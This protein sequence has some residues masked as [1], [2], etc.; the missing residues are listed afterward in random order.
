M[1]TPEYL[2]KCTDDV[3]R[4]YEQLNENITRDIARRI[5][6]TGE[7]TWTAKW[8]AKQSMQAGRLFEDI[9]NDV[10][11]YSGKTDAEIR[12]LFEDAGVTAL[13]YDNAPLIAAGWNAPTG[14]SDPMM[15]VLEANLRKTQG[16]LRTLTM[17]TA[18]LGQQAFF[19]STNEAVMMVESGAFDYNTAIRR[20]IDKAAK[21]GAQVMYD[22]GTRLSV[23]AAVRMNVL[24]GV[25]QTAS[26]ISIMNGEMLGCEYYETTAHNGARAEHI[27]WQG[28]VF[29]I[30]GSDPDHDNFYDATGYGTV[31][32]LCGANCRHSFF[33]FFPDISVPAYTEE[34][35]EALAE[36]TVTFNG[37]EYTEYEASQIQRRYERAI[38]ESKRA[39]EGFK[40]AMEETDDEDLK[41][42]LDEA[43][44]EA[45]QKLNARRQKL[46]D[47][48]EQTGRKKDSNRHKVAP[49]YVNGRKVGVVSVRDEGKAL[50]ASLDQTGK[51]IV[52]SKIEIAVVYDSKGNEVFRHS[53][54]ESDRVD[55]TENQV[56]KM[57]GNHLLHNHQTEGTLGV[58]DV[59]TLI[60]GE[61]KS[62]RAQCHEIVYKLERLN[63]EYDRKRF[64]EDYESFFL[65]EKGVYDKK[66]HDIEA[67]RYNN[68]EKYL[69]E[70]GKN[71]NELNNKMRRWLMDNSK[72]YGF[73][74]SEFKK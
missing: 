1:L 4:L 12:K 40:A 8:Q 61:L 59:N 21:G 45:Q 13:K 17:T 29:K 62:I 14:L 5:V 19:D 38:R 28:R 3:V 22:S 37:V 20:A 32:G 24:T 34:K 73:R 67:L 51:E 33:P 6:K 39:V 11:Q 52:K 25:N 36:R 44:K 10:S 43:R 49:V 9:I 50:L 46:T 63:G 42:S 47:F 57:K 54:G 64:K 56:K 53:Q 15:N 72:N 18:S 48:T 65:G 68:T 60:K 35:L 7:M 27:P 69:S 23:E 70:F 71:I 30:H 2:S 16:D 66:Q 31:T 74:Y 41:K 58:D 55:F 26:K